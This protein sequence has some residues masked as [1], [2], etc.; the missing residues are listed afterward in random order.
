[1][2]LGQEPESSVTRAAVGGKTVGR[3]AELASVTGTT[4]TL[5]NGK[6]PSGT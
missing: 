1:M 5:R 2:V 6:G 3:D 4:P